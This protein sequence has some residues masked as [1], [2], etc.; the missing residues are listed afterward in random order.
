ME[1]IDKH[2]PARRRRVGK[3]KAPWI[4]NELQ[5][6]MHVR[7]YLKKQA[8]NLNDSVSRDKFKIARNETNNAIKYAKKQY[9][10]QFKP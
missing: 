9:V 3:K 10:L 5:N 6:K 4:T 2:A 8:V 7:N 1:C